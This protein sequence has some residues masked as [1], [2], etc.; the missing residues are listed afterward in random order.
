VKRRFDLG[1]GESIVAEWAAGLPS[2]SGRTATYG[3]TLVLTTDRL[4]WEALRLPPG[5]NLMAGG[6]FLDRLTSGVPLHEILEVQ[7]DER[8]PGLLHVRTGNGEAK[9]LVSASRWSPIWSKRNRVARDDAVGR[10]R[11]S[12]GR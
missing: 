8:R 2:R 7:A 11:S 3:G 9:F 5:L 1:P 6:S 12:I 4:I 10:I